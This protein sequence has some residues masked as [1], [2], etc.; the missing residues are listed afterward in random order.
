MVRMHGWIRTM[1]TMRAVRA[2]RVETWRWIMR[3]V[4]VHTKQVHVRIIV[5]QHVCF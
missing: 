1:R 2:V 3:E 4:L 5:D